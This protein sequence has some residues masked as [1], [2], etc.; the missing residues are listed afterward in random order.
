MKQRNHFLD[1]AKGIAIIMV[2]ITHFSWENEERLRYFFPFWISM[3]VPI[4]LI[5]TGYVSTASFEKKGVDSMMQAY[6]KKL[7]VHKL[8]RYSIPFCI[9]YAADIVLHSMFEKRAGLR[10]IVVNFLRGGFGGAGTYYYPI[11][12]QVIFLFPIIYF[13]VKRYKNGLW[14]CFGLNVIY[15]ILAR[16]WM[17]NGECYRLLAF[18]YIMLIAFGCYLYEYKENKLGK[19]NWILFFAGIAFIIATDYLKYDPVT[20][21]YWKRTCVYAILYFLPV[22]SFMMEHLKD[23]HSRLL[24]LFGNASYHIFFIQMLYY[25]YADDHVGTLIQNQIC[26]VLLN[27]VICTILGVIFYYI[28]TPFS[29][30]VMKKADQLMNRQLKGIKKSA[31]LMLVLVSL[32]GMLVVPCEKVMADEVIVITPE[33]EMDAEVISGEETV[34]EPEVPD[35]E[36]A[37]TIELTH[38]ASFQ[39]KAVKNGIRLSWKASSGAQKYEI[40][41]K[42]KGEDSYTQIHTT[43]KCAY[44]D[45][46]AENGIT[47]V[48]KV[49]AV[50][51][52]EDQTYTSICSV[53]KS[54]CTYRVDPSKPMVALTFDDGPSQYTEGIL[55]ALEN[56]DARATFF[57]LGNRVKQYPDVVLR[58]DQIGCEI[59]NHSYDHAILGNASSA[60]IAQEIKKT[61][62]SIKKITGKKPVLLRPPYGSIGSNLRK[63]AGKPMILWSID[64]LDW[65]TKSADKVYQC[66]MNQVKDGDIILMHDLYKSSREAAK[67]LIPAL[68]KKGY[69]MV[70]VSELAEY[71]QVDLKAGE[72]YSQMR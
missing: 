47:Y 19:K 59:G 16:V 56:N 28:E 61:D 10:E 71:K 41:R 70:T 15:E 3:A 23:V 42:E 8:L 54:C 63:N 55:D 45:K 33:E 22:F 7:I 34:D 6:E 43:A 24:E 52:A 50:A 31:A 18:R 40:F 32:T 66:V 51:V 12:L 39:A 68:K 49:R 13:I 9:A 5:I 20:V 27:I 72:R 30:F 44:T 69:Q 65:K 21:H 26:H 11:L 29:N 36:I 57:E 53:K 38:P 2:I 17:L 60:K 1:V 37:Q 64:T 35:E 62:T 67:R 48:Y 46:T 25:N 14:I 4:F 58:I